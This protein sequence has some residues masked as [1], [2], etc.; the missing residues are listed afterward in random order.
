MNKLLVINIVGL[1]R[2]LIGKSTP[3]LLKLIEQKSSTHQLRALAPTF[4]AVTCSAQA[5]LLTGLSPSEH[6]IV[7][8][9]W[10][11]KDLSEIMFWKQS[12]ALVQGESLWTSLKKISPKIKTANTFWWYNMYCQADVSV[13]PRPLYPADGRK[14]PDCYTHP[15]SLR[16]KL[17]KTLGLFPLFKFWGPMTSIV[18]SRW[19]ANASEQIQK[20]FDPDF[21]AVYLPHLDYCLQ[22]HGPNSDKIA[23]DLKEVDE[24][25]GWYLTNPV[26]KNHQIV[27]LSEYGISDVAKSISLNR[28]LRTAGLLVIKSEMGRDTLDAGASQ[29]FAVADHQVAHVYVNDKSNLI[30]VKKLLQQTPGVLK[31]LDKSE[32]EQLKINHDRSG[33]LVCIANSGYWFDYYFWFDDKKAPDYARTVDIHRK[34]GY[35]PV[36]LF[37]NPKLMLPQLKIALKLLWRKLGGRAL[38]DVIG[39]DSTLVK[40]SHGAIPESLDDYPVFIYP[41]ELATGVHLKMS[42]KNS[43]ADEVLSPLGFKSFVHDYFSSIDLTVKPKT[44]LSASS[45]GL[46]EYR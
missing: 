24:I 42:V 15:L 10:Y 39:F 21:H 34:P 22:K 17:T 1:S 12:N 46:Q 5:T 32:Q 38:L 3:N 26:F 41:K 13:T 7:G 11:F 20:D 14:I 31:V 30:V 2:K 44:S 36:E 23:K 37:I 9:G 28:V 40:G 6:G 43:A 25:I 18:A 29:A 8:N 27:F 35:D 33:D 45:Q 19:I 4:P 16:D